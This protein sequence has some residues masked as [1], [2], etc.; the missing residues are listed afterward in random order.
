MARISFTLGTIA[1]AAAFFGAASAQSGAWGQ[2]GWTTSL[3][4]GLVSTTFF[5]AAELAGRVPRRV[6]ADTLAH[7]RVSIIALASVDFTEITAR[8]QTIGIGGHLIALTARRL[9]YPLH[10]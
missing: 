4:Q 6:S 1:A 10:F 7:I 3:Q 9:I 2:V 8:H 5:S